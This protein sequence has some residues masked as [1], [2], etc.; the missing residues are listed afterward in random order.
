M[1]KTVEEA[2]AVA[3][4]TRHKRHFI[5]EDEVV[6]LS[7]GTGIAVATMWGADNLKG[8]LERASEFGYVPKEDGDASVV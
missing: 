2:R 8:F 6:T 5:S 4:R 1:F 3:Q 7:D